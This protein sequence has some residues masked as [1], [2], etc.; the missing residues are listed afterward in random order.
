MI[1]LN[2]YDTNPGISGTKL[3]RMNTRSLAASLAVLLAILAPAA[4][5]TFDKTDSGKTAAG[6]LKLGVGARAMGMGEAFSAIADDGTSIFWNPAGMTRVNGASLSVMHATYLD[7]SY[8]DYGGYVHQFP[9]GSVGTSIQ[10]LSQ[11]T[12]QGT[13]ANNVDSVEFSPKDV[14]MTF[15][16]ARKYSL[17][18]VGIG[19][20][21]ISSKIIN[22]A[23]TGAVDIG[24]LSKGFFED[25][26]RASFV[27]SNMGGT[28]RFDTEEW[29]IPTIIRTGLSWETDRYTFGLD[30]ISPRDNDP[31]GALGVEYKIRA[32]KQRRFFMRAGYNTRSVG[33]VDGAVGFT[34]GLG[35][36][37]KRIALD[38]A[39]VPMGGLGLTHRISMTFGFGGVDEEGPIPLRKKKKK[40]RKK[41]VRIDRIRPESPRERYQ[42][43][44]RESIALIKARKNWEALKKVRSATAIQPMEPESHIIEGRILYVEGDRQGAERSFRKSIKLLS[45]SDRRTAYVHERMGRIAYRD[46][47]YKTAKKHYQKVINSARRLKVK[48]R[49]LGNAYAGL[50]LVQHREHDRAPALRNL[51]TGASMGITR[52]Y[53]KE[54]NAAF[55][56]P[57]WN[58]KGYKGR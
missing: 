17:F 25:R 19:A 47:D 41:S 4:A 6:F 28:L 14:A 7:S 33:D 40:K 26:L 3:Y 44:M 52:E 43:L 50:G 15:A 37:I 42:A 24:I 38:Y 53:K 29:E 56:N 45:R 39:F 34:A 23:Q 21:F 54:I 8:Y 10:F 20:K 49:I 57:R 30:A 48:K 55:N 46:G 5:T 51:R 36:A 12:I 11:G 22:T 9:W 27:A 16:Y 31:Y 1:K 35:M 2:N 32:K 13:D 18:S 58:K